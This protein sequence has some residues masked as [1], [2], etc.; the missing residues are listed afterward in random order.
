MVLKDQ[1]LQEKKISEFEDRAIEIPSE[2]QKEEYK[3]K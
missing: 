3:K 1:T 2:A